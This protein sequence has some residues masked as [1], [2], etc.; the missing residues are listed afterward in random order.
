MDVK[1]FLLDF[2]DYLAPKLDTYEAAL[3]LY[4]VRHVRLEDKEE[5]TVAF[6]SARRRMARGI[7]EHGKPMSESTVREKLQ[8][9]EQKKAIRVEGVTHTGTVV[10]VFLPAEIVDVVPAENEDTDGA[11]NIETMDFF[12]PSWRKLILEREERCCFYTLE[13]LDES[14]FVI[15]HVVPRSQGGD[16]SYKNVVACSRSANNRKRAMS[17]EDFLLQLWRDGSLSDSD[18]PGRLKALERL[19]QGQLKPRIEAPVRD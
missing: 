17:A 19:K 16:N 1:Q 3:Y 4:L 9:L 10:R 6:K 2:Q 15:D 5:G 8:S 18:L 12:D 13:Q 11:L 14:N 7:G